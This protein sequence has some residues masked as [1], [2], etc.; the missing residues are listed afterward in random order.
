MLKD[1]KLDRVFV[2]DIETIPQQENFNELPVH[3]QHLWDQ[4]SSYQRTDG[5]S[6]AEFYERAGIWAEFGKI[7]CIS[8]GIFHLSQKK[9]NLRVSSFANEDEKLLLRQFIDLLNNQARHIQLCA[10]N[11]K[12]FD[13][14]YLCRRILINGLR[15]PAVL[16][17]AGKKPWEINH[18]DTLELWKFGDYKNYTSLN[19]LAAIFGLPT[20]KN[21][22]DGSMVKQTYYLE[23]D[24]DRI[25]RY[26]ENDV[27][28]TAQILLRFKG[29]AIIPPENI[30]LVK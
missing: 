22:L 1:I 14:P 9:I 17:I 7:V 10:H 28:T 18:I 15:I 4:K 16:Q 19:L 20:P 30:T 29:L 11:G 12:E 23:K 25:V 21:D 6:P 13:F 5:Q 24:L 8:V 27:I 3:L 26:C 2:I